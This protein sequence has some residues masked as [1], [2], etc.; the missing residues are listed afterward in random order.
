MR[1]LI[2]DDVHPVLF[3]GFD[4]LGISY[5]YFPDMNRI[6]AEKIIS[7][8]EGLVIRSKFKV[9]TSFIDLAT[10]LKFIARAGAG[11]DTIDEQYVEH[12]NIVVFHASEGNKVAVAEHTLGMLL[13]LTNKIHLA[14][15]SVRLNQWEREAHRGVELF[16][17][18]FGIIGYGNM[19]S[20]VAK[21]A[22]VFFNKK[23]MVYDKYKKIRPDSYIQSV[24]LDTFLKEVEIISLHIPLI[25][26]NKYLINA[27]FIDRMHHPFWLINTSR[28]EV[29]SF[30]SVRYGIETQKIIGIGL[31]VLENEKIHQLTKEQ[32]I[33]FDFLKQQPN[34]LFTPHIAGW[35]VESYKKISEVLV[36]K[37]NSWL[38]P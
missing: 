11:L 3:E 38:N 2:V 16:E 33:D 5:D 31:D 23:I 14:D 18:Q 17:K 12:K 26:E 7:N 6:E 10:Q 37:I 30:A 34:V 20:E 21:R 25:E 35:S 29:M 27:S 19:G 13:S 4:R 22:S 36:E 9:D 28:G 8:Y 24:D 1:C 32:Q 15:R